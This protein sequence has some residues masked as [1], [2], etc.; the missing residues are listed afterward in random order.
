M[1]IYEFEV[2]IYQYKEV[3]ADSPEE[4]KALLEAEHSLDDCL[5]ELFQIVEPRK[6]LTEKELEE[7]DKLLDRLESLGTE[8]DMKEYEDL[9]DDKSK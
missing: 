6:P 1:P 9:H 2:T 8:D 4:A 7:M 5:I 3:E